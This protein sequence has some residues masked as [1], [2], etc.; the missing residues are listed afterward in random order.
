MLAVALGSERGQEGKDISCDLVLSKVDIILSKNS[1]A[2]FGSPP[3][4]KMCV[5]SAESP[6]GTDGRAPNCRGR[7]VGH[8]L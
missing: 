8:G 5:E 3:L 6:I 4:G 2:I 1:P 7:G